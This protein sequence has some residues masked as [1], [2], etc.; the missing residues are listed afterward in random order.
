MNQFLK[1][2][3]LFLSVPIVM[4]GLTE[5]ICLRNMKEKVE[6]RFKDLAKSKVLLMGDSQI[7]RL[8]SSLFKNNTAMLASSGEPY[9]VTYSKLNRILDQDSVDA[10]EVILGIAPHNFSPVYNK[11]LDYDWPEGKKSKKQ[12]FFFLDF[13][14]NRYFNFRDMLSPKMVE[15]LWS[16]PE[17]GGYVVSEYSNPDSLTIDK[18]FKNHY[19]D[20]S[21]KYRSEGMQMEYLIR[22]SD[23]CEKSGIKL[24]LLSTPYHKDYLKRINPKYFDLMSKAI[25]TINYS[26]RVDFLKDS[27]VS[28]FMSDANH[29][30]SAGSEFYTRNLLKQI[31]IK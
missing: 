4:I 28:E 6:V 7:Q 20:D 9:Y 26:T 27:V 19:E 11:I 29:L 22:I 21:L 31:D 24:H 23:L 10:E 3:V 13:P 30:N 2:L 16:K 15:L 14:E 18:I 17:W 5:L 8:D 25:D 12:Y 1:R